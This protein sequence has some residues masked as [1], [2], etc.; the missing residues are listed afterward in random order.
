VGLLDDALGA[1]GGRGGGS[2]NQVLGAV[3]GLLERAGGLEGVMSKLESS[4]LGDK[5]QSWIGTG[6]NTAISRGEVKQALGDDEVKT[7]AREAGVS[8]DEAADG[9]AGLLPE[10]VDRI[11]PGG[12]LPDVGQLGSAVGGLLKGR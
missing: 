4:G 7:V 6:D 10:I 1:V 5:V 11:S 2:G 3:S 12:K 9:L 8:E